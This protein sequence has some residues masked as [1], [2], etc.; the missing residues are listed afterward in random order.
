MAMQE[1]QDVGSG[2]DDDEVFLQARAGFFENPTQKS[3]FVHRGHVDVKKPKDKA[4]TY[5]P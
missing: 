3:V 4:C 5:N 1:D 2:L